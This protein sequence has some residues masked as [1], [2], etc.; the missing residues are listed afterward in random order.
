M[1]ALT[2]DKALYLL[3]LI[4]L[5]W[6]SL[7]DIKHK[8]ISNQWIYF[9]LALT[10]ILWIAFPD[11]YAVTGQKLLYSLTFFAVGFVLYLIKIIGAGDS[12]YLASL[13]L[14][15]PINWCELALYSLFLSTLIIGGFVFFTTV[16]KKYDQLWPSFMARDYAQVAKLLNNRFSYAPVI[17]VSWVLL[18]VLVF[19]KTTFVH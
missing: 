12:K 5:F 7:I 18:G 1:T 10:A 4:Q 8:K 14:V 6:V 3:I 15:I 19:W 16:V 17:L 13:Y 9:N 2:I 11:N